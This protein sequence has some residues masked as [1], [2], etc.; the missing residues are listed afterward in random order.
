MRGTDVFRYGI[1]KKT[2]VISDKLRDLNPDVQIDELHVPVSTLSAEHLEGFGYLCLCLPNP[3]LIE[4]TD[5]LCRSAGTKFW[6]VGTFG[7]C[8]YIFTDAN[9]HEYSRY[10]GYFFARIQTYVEQYQW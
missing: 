6:A 1:T 4:R 10:A 7:L 3:A 8:G 2:A 9:N 5:T